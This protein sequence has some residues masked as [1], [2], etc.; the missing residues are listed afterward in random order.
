MPCACLWL[1]EYMFLS[2]SFSFACWD[3]GWG[4][5]HGQSGGNS[6]GCKSDNWCIPP[7]F[8]NSGS[9][10]HLDDSGARLDAFFNSRLERGVGE[11]GGTKTL[12]TRT[13]CQVG[14][15]IVECRPRLRSWRIIFDGRRE[16]WKWKCRV[17][18]SRWAVS[19]T[20]VV[21][22]GWEVTVH[23]MPSAGRSPESPGPGEDCR[24][25]QGWTP[26]LRTQYSG[27]GF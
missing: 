26:F 6:C 20:V 17:V 22:G 14:R 19:E 12:S 3:R 25:L 21:A 11:E 4:A 5:R 10:V 16:V 8:K 24:R 15:S 7:E 18:T 13:L 23:M 2:C 1:W 9:T 27:V